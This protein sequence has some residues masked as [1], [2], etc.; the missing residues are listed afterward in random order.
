MVVSVN[1][2]KW[3]LNLGGGTFVRVIS[4]F[5]NIGENFSHGTVTRN[6]EAYTRSNSW[7]PTLATRQRLICSRASSSA[8]VSKVR[9]TE[10]ILMCY[11]DV[12]FN[13][14]ASASVLL[15]CMSISLFDSSIAFIAS[16]FS[17]SISSSFS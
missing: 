12:P 17:A 13:L 7:G 8:A 6:R 9:S 16:F 15:F 14:N 3:S 4:I 1:I 11:V 2:G 5:G 10:G